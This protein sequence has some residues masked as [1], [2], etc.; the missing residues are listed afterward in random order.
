MNQFSTVSGKL[1]PSTKQALKEFCNVFPK[2]TRL[3]SKCYLDGRYFNYIMG[4][5]EGTVKEPIYI[6]IE[7]GELTSDPTDGNKREFT[8]A[9]AWDESS[10]KRTSGTVRFI[11]LVIEIGK[12]GKQE[13]SRHSNLIWIDTRNK[14]IN[15]FEPRWNTYTPVINDMLKDYFSEKMEG[16]K[17]RMIPEH[18]Q[19]LENEICPGKGFCSAFILKKAMMLVTGHHCPWH[20]DPET[21]MR[22]IMRFSAAVE[23]YYGILPGEPLLEYGFWDS[24]SPTTKVLAGGAAGGLI[25]GILTRSWSGALAGGLIGGAGTY[26]LTRNK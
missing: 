11:K 19:F 15:R 14:T 17:F 6:G 25:G 9:L 18:P 5:Y 7:E 16:Y 26:L 3:S 4:V 24:W 13:I 1:R 22:D 23:D 20:K 12:I 2:S 10:L 8:S 21:A